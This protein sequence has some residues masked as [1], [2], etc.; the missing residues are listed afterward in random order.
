MIKALD[1]IIH[2]KQALYFM[3]LTIQNQFLVYRIKSEGVK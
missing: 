1:F 3:H 2:I